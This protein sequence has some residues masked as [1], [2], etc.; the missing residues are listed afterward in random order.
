[1]STTQNINVLVVDKKLN[2]LSLFLTGILNINNVIQ[3]DENTTPESVITLIKSISD[4][5]ENGI[6]NI[7]LGFV[8]HNKGVVQCPFFNSVNSSQI[9]NVNKTDNINTSANNANIK[10]NIQSK[11]T[12]NVGAPAFSQTLMTMLYDIKHMF[13]NLN[14]TVNLALDLITCDSNLFNYNKISKQLNITIRY[15]TNP[16]GDISNWTMN[17]PTTFS[18]HD[19]YFNNNITNWTYTLSVSPND[20]RLALV[21]GTEPNLSKYISFTQSKK[22]SGSGTFKLNKNIFWPYDVNNNDY[23]INLLNGDIFDGEQHTIT[24]GDG[25]DSN[26]GIFGINLDGLLNLQLS[27]PVIKDLSIKSQIVSPSDSVGG[28]GFIR[29]ASQDFRAI[30]CHHT[31]TINCVNGGG[32]CSQPFLN[33]SDSQLH[34][35]YISSCSQTGNIINGN[36]G[37]GGIVGGGFGNNL[38][39][40]NTNQLTINLKFNIRKCYSKMTSIGSDNVGGIIGSES[41]NNLGCIGNGNNYNTTTDSIVNITGKFTQCHFNGNLSGNNCGGICAGG[42]INNNN[43]GGG[44]IGNNNNIGGFNFDNGGNGGNGDGTITLNILFDHC[45]SK[46]NLS[47]NNC[48]GICAGGDINNN[49]IGGG[50]IGN[51]NNIGGFNF[52]FN[53][54]GNGGNGGGIIT[55]NILFDHCF[56]K[57]NLSGNNCGGI[58]AG[59]DINNNNIG[60]GCIGNN[61]NIGGF[62]FGN[63]SGNGGNGDGTITLNILFDRCFS[64]GNLSG[65]NCGGI[66]AGGNN[67]GSIGGGCIGNNNNIGGFNFNGNGN[68]GNGDGTMTLNVLFDHCFSKGN[69]SGNNCGGICAGGNNNDFIGGGCIG[70]NNNIGGFNFGGGNGGNGGGTITFNV[71]FDHCFSK[72][73]LSG[74]NCAGICAGGDN[75]IYI[76]GGCIGNN[77]NIG[78]FSFGNNGGNGGGTITL[79]ILFEHCSSKGNLSENNCG[80]ICAGG[81]NNY[82]GGGCIGN[83]NNIGGINVGGDGSGNGINGGTLLIRAK[84]TKCHVNITSDGNFNSGLCAGFIGCYNSNN[85]TH[86]GQNFTIKLDVK[87]CT[88]IFVNKTG[89]GNSGLLGSIGNFNTTTAGSGYDPYILIVNV[90][91][92]TVS[93]DVN[94]FYSSSV[95]GSQYLNNNYVSLNNGNTSGITSDNIIIRVYK[96]K[97]NGS[98]DG[99]MCGGIAPSYIGLINNNM[100]FSLNIEKC[101][102]KLNK[103]GIKHQHIQPVSLNSSI[104]TGGCGGILGSFVNGNTTDQLININHCKVKVTDGKVADYCGGFCGNNINNIVLENCSGAGKRTGK[105]YK[106]LSDP[107]N[108][109]IQHVKWN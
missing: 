79:T 80:G 82:I 40:S 62:N 99:T 9:T 59:G 98:I 38:N 72:E 8:Y 19:L 86:N 63:G 107:L 73:N 24:F 17:N 97:V 55:L 49:N 109:T 29:N 75:N 60:G 53:G 48:G 101:S 65:N 50:C 76:G 34:S 1:M 10:P 87:N 91:K 35:I 47:G 89:N 46:G 94:N 31:G 68:G 33:V 16:M 67:N 18:I 57:G 39:N 100:P 95:F 3:Y 37:C 36:N 5:N 32:I 44:C 14:A 28:G 96:V 105:S 11:V 23:I 64:K 81:N 41:V 90:S 45:F 70:N 88:C 21:N 13:N 78:G 102:L 51:N 61:N 22:I 52:N 30:N 106:Y 43:I 104:E 42:D 74:N 26:F 108:N 92:C 71:S 15:D 85:S 83:N 6:F 4:G 2:N 27:L 77:N 25:S 7:N 54:N 103:I 20:I 93:M 56:S 12:G 69:L 84:L 66:C 58:C